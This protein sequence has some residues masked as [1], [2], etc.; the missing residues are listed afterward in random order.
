MLMDK[1]REGAQGRIAKIIF[2]LII[3]SFVLAGV[4]SYL[5]QPADTDP[6]EVNGESISA[7]ELENAYRNE[8]SRLEAQYGDAFAQLTADPNY[9]PQLR[10]GVLERLVNQ[11]LLDQHS[12]DA[13]LRVA[14]AEIRAAIRAMPEFQQDGKFDNQR[15]LALIGRAG[16]SPEQFSESLRQDLVRQT[17]VSGLLGSEFVLPQETALVDRLYQQTRDAKLYRVPVA[18]FVP[19]V[20]VS[21]EELQQYYQ[22]NGKAFMH[23]EQVKLNYLLLD[24][25]DLEKDISVS[26]SDLQ[27][28]YDQHQDEYRTAE[29]RKV[30]HILIS[31]KDETVARQKI[32]AVQARLKAGEA[33]D[34]LA[35][36]ESADALSA[37]EGGE[38][39][40]F[41][42]GVMDPAFEQAAFALQQ[43][44][45][46]SAPVKSA[47]GYHLI[48]LL[49]VEPEQTKTFASVK[50]DVAGKLRRE[51]AQERF[52]DL[53]QR[54]ADLSFENP[55]ALEPVAESLQLS[56]KSTEFIGA[57]SQQAPFDAPKV[58]AQAF[59][60][61][62]RQENTNSEVIALSDSQALVLHVLDYQPAS[63]RPFDE[64]KEQVSLA[65][66]QAKATELARAQAEQL[67]AKL[68]A[69]EPVEALLQPF[70][71]QEEALTAVAR[72]GAGAQLEPSLV[73]ALFRMPKPADQQASL[74]R[75]AQPGGDQVV[76]MLQ[77]VQEQTQ[78]SAFREQLQTGM[79]RGKSDAAYAALLVELKAKADIQYH[80]QN[81]PT[82]E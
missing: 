9:L 82:A 60:E 53:Q 20:Q 69:G 48:K 17:Y 24:A 21:D 54:L 38:L 42:P 18:H 22:A 73:Q 11:L 71:G 57:D 46:L 56:L 62:L 4:G 35:R 10:Q 2:W 37:R 36:S 8:R 47:F 45:E 81:L 64:V 80:M 55:D 7:Q 19:L 61:T 50:A 40:W 13:G 6:A 25:H 63:V 79:V 43:P 76:L 26:D 41:E 49:A 34:Q 52:L 72:Y 68:K 65:V 27:A 67:L 33:F 39:D 23:P 29:R 75:V 12:R 5:D 58:R 28:Y 66:K 59:S 77:R 31:D 44:G 70:G 3:L 78:P 16:M 32:D 14:D 1:L 30:A 15:Y 51:K 74:Q